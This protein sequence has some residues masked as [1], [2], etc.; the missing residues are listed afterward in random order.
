MPSQHATQGIPGAL[1]VLAALLHSVCTIHTCSKEAIFPEV[2]GNF[3]AGTANVQAFTAA[4]AAAMEPHPLWHGP[5]PVCS[6]LSQFPAPS[7]HFPLPSSV[8]C[9]QF[10]A[11]VPC[12]SSLPPVPK[13]FKAISNKQ[14]SKPMRKPRSRSR[15]SLVTLELECFTVS[16]ATGNIRASS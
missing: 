15:V 9:P 3:P 10:P 4:F 5:L 8:C 7:L 12:P 2:E 13:S 16:T 1:Q 14:E 6:S 11:P